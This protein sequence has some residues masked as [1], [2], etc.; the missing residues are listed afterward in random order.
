MKRNKA[1]RRH[2]ALLLPGF[3]KLG[4][5]EFGGS[6]LKGNPREARPLVTKRP[7]HPVLRSTLATGDKSFLNPSR[8]RKIKWLVH[9]IGKQVGVKVYR[10]ANSGNH[11]HLVILARSRPAFIK[12]VKSISGLIARLTMGTERGSPLGRKFWDARPFTKIIEW[13]REFRA[14]SN[15][16]LQNTMEALGFVAYTPRKRKN[17]SQ[18]SMWRGSTGIA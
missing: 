15:Y 5:K 12:Y 4:S 13:G 2:E 10:Y 17:H 3:K 7:M 14:L 9:R 6:L 18:S 1:P 16:V 8:A 11:L